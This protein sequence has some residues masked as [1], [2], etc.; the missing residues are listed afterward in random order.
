MQVA[1]NDNLNS[2]TYNF[3]SNVHL[4]SCVGG[5]ISMSNHVSGFIL[6][7]L[8]VTAQ[9]LFI[10]IIIMFICYLL[11][12]FYYCVYLNFLDIYKN[13]SKSSYFC[14]PFAREYK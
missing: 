2:Q 4:C 13:W 11:Y 3:L 1:D 12:L 14:H 7:Y 10:I 8:P 6:P 9:V 5:D